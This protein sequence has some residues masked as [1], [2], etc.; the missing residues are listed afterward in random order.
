MGDLISLSS[1][2]AQKAQNDD[3]KVMLQESYESVVVANYIDSNLDE[4][5]VNGQFDKFPPIGENRS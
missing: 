1:V 2:K 5:S 4:T 3:D